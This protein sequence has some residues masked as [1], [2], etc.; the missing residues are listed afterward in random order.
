MDHVLTER[1]QSYVPVECDI[2]YTELFGTQND[3]GEACQI[4]GHV[5]QVMLSKES[6]INMAPIWNAFGKTA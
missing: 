2:C 4:H 3:S 5:N 1:A 6:H